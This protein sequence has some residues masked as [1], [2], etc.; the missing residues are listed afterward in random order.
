MKESD[1]FPL[2]CRDAEMNLITEQIIRYT[3]A[4]HSSDTET[5]RTKP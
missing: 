2:V 4:K 1:L 3:E 5:F